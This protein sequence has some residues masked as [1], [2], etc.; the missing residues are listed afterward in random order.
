MVMGMNQCGE[1]DMSEPLMVNIKDVPAAAVAPTGDTDLCEGT[2]TTMYAATEIMYADDYNW[3]IMPEEAG[4]IMA[5]GME[6]EVTWNSE[7]A[8]EAEIYVTGVN[9]C[10]EGETSSALMVMMTAMPEM[11]AM[12]TGDTELCENNATTMYETA[13]AN[14]AEAYVWEVIPA[15][16]GTVVSDGMTA[17][18]TWA[19]GYSGDANVHV[20]AMNPCG[21]SEFSDAIMVTLAPLPAQPETITGQDEV[22]QGLTITLDVS[23]I[24]NATDCEW[25]IEPAEAGVVSMNGTSC[26][27]TVSESWE[28]DATIM[29]RGTN[30]CGA[31]AW[32]DGFTMTIQDCTGID[33]NEAISLEVYPNPNNGDFTISLEANETINIRLMNAIGEVVYY[34]NN[35]E[36]FGTV[37]KQ[38]STSGL[39]NGVYYLNLSGETVNGFQKIVIRR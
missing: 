14:G 2:A 5:N 37:S 15:E 27:V 19:E 23:E 30:D 35:V 6:A 26:D 13:G 22:C 7:W 39:A 34:E 29:V 24:T 3:T 32:S 18:V 1:G 8:G 38:I 20:K 21:E 28:G 12:P 9:E 25:M 31:G 17:E 33:E 11:P 4:T 36:V 10:G 16:A